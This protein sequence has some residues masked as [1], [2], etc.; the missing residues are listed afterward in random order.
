MVRDCL[1]L[2]HCNVSSFGKSKLFVLPN[3]SEKSCKWISNTPIR[4]LSTN[5][6][7]KKL[8]ILVSSPADFDFWFFFLIFHNDDFS[9]RWFFTTIIFP[10]LF[11]HQNF[12]TITSFS[13]WFFIFKFCHHKEIPILISNFWILIAAAFLFPKIVYLKF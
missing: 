3:L 9:Q 7:K 6:F 13:F 4:S 8:V 12:F 5:L 10:R 2:E 11:S 1:C